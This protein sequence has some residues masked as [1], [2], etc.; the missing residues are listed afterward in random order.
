M[1]VHT[2]TVFQGYAKSSA[3]L[4]YRLNILLLMGK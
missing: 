4:P 3:R 2:L 1:G